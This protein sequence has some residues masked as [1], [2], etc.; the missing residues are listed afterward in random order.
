M[1]RDIRT[2]YVA[3]LDRLT[4]RGMAYVGLILDELERVGGRIVFVA[5]GLDSSKPG[6]RHI[7]AI[8]AEQVRAESDAI[9]W[10]IGEWHAHNRR[11]G[12]WKQRRPFGYLVVDG[13]LRLHPVEAPIIRRMADDFLAGA[14]LRSVARWLNKEGVKPP[15]VA[16]WYE[17]AQAKGHRA[18]M[19]S[20]QTWASVSVKSVLSQP[21]AAGLV[22]HHGKLVYDE[23]GGLVFAGDGI[24]TLDERASILAE[25]ERRSALVRSAADA[26]RVGGRAGEGRPA[27][28]L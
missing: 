4:R 8:Q 15:R 19:P 27:K 5:E 25:L 28:Y 22:S 3:R 14:S 1:V 23:H 21:A 9:G 2:L 18:K 17:E 24:V 16:I 20:N 6:A 10:R 7:I 26:G 12:L 11:Q 13:R